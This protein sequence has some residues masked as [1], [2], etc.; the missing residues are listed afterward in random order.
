M[1]NSVLLLALLL[2]MSG[3]FLLRFRYNKPESSSSFEHVVGDAS[4]RNLFI[5]EPKYED[6]QP[7]DALE[8]ITVCIEATAECNEEGIATLTFSPD[9]APATNAFR[10]QPGSMGAPETLQGVFWLQQGVGGSVLTSFSK[11]RIGGGIDTGVWQE[12]AEGFEYLR[13]PM[14]DHSWAFAME[15]NESQFGTEDVARLLDIVYE[16]DITKGAWKV[17]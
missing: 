14:G 1:G 4:R 16:L 6:R 8:R 12:N 13:R 17:L 9:E 5:L 11:T 15:P 10:Y 7:R 2:F 3:W